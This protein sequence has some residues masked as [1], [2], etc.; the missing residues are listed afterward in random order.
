MA[1][2]RRLKQFLGGFSRVHKGSIQLCEGL[3]PGVLWPA[4]W[5]PFTASS[6]RFCGEVVVCGVSR[7]GLIPER[8][9]YPETQI[10]IVHPQQGLNPK[11]Q[12]LNPKP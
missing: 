12:T 3:P 11:P 6:K 7:D 2:G 9:L 1:V 5:V 10:E 4:V 8:R